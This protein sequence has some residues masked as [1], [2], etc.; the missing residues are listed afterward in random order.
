MKVTEQDQADCFWWQIYKND[1]FA[2][3][4]FPMVVFGA[5]TPIACS[6]F[7][8]VF[9][10]SYSYENVPRERKTTTE[11]DKEECWENRT[12]MEKRHWW[13]PLLVNVNLVNVWFLVFVSAFS[14][15]VPLGMA[16]FEVR[17]L[18]EVKIRACLFVCLFVFLVKKNSGSIL[19]GSKVNMASYL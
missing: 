6:A 11:N 10:V 13:I 9:D 16:S 18:H 12:E 2:S 19:L 17:I 7:N 5:Y 15:Y 3:L 14:S 8:S 1:S 4:C